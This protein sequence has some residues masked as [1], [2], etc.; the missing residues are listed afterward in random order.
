MPLIEISDGLPSALEPL[1]QRAAQA[2]L[3]QQQ[4]PPQTELTVMLSD[5]RQLQELNRQFL[6]I[7]APT[8]VLSFPALEVDPET[9][10]TYLGDIA[11]SYER[12]LAQAHTGGHAV[13][14]E[15]QLL[16]VHGVL[17][18]LGYDHAD[19]QAKEAM[20]SA[21]SSILNALG[22]PLAPP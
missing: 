22:I 15:L 1:L 20:W 2:T 3:V 7:D 21:Q 13:E 16:V 19:P 6:G 11:I 12:A 18:L 17:H 8:D 5:D 4:Q 14:D 9:G 10:E